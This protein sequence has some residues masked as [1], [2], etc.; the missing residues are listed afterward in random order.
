[1]RVIVT[2]PIAQAAPWVQALQALGIDAVA[3]PLIAIEPAERAPIA[4]AWAHLNGAALAM[5]VSPNAVQ[6][7]FEARP[8]GQPWPA[9]TRAGSTGPG[10]S[11]ALRAAG[12]DEAQLVEPPP[13]G[14]FDTETLWQRL[15][16]EPWQGRRVLIVRGDGGRDWLAQTL[17]AAGAQVDFVTAYRRRAPRLDRALVDAALQAPAAHCWHFSSSEAID[18]LL[19]AVPGADWR[20]CRAEATHPRIAERARRAGFGRVGLVGV[21]VDELAARLRAPAAGAASQG[22][23]IESPPL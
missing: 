12:I 15:Q 19:A 1:M 8:P 22:A 13:D 14:P 18:H 10:T 6:H 5:F 20:A 2:R 3:L 17:R 23:S 21:R 9:A 4:A 11:A 7:F 16:A